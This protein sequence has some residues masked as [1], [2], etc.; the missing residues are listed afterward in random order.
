MPAHLKIKKN[1]K[2]LSSNDKDRVNS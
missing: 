1:D 2:L